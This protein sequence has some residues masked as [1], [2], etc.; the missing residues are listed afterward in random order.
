M[1]EISTIPVVSEGKGVETPTTAV[2]LED[3]ESADLASWAAKKKNPR[4]IAR[5]TFC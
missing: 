3:R 4:M 1:V 2:A 5:L